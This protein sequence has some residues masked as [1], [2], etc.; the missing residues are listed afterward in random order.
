MIV[1]RPTTDSSGWLMTFWP[2]A[3]SCERSESIISGHLRI[4]EDLGKAR[5]LVRQL[6]QQVLA[7]GDHAREFTEKLGELL[8][9]FRDQPEQDQNQQGHKAEKD[10]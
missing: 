9:Q 1:I 10:Q 2:T 3:I 4:R 8:K 5:V 6:H 7:L